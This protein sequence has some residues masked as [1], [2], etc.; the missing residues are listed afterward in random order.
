MLALGIQCDLINFPLS[1]I[2]IDDDRRRDSEIE[3]ELYR[4]RLEELDNAIAEL[5]ESRP[6][7]SADSSLRRT[8]SERESTAVSAA[9]QSSNSS[10]SSVR[11]TRSERRTHHRQLHTEH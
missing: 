7:T 6:D 9:A 11:R 2:V 10:R 4:A 3:R 1:C 8:E 5:L